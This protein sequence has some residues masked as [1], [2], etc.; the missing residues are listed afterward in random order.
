MCEGLVHLRRSVTQ[1]EPQ[2]FHKK[3][4]STTQ[5]HQENAK[6]SYKASIILIFLDCLF[7]MF[8]IIH[9][10]SLQQNANGQN[11][12]KSEQTASVHKAEL[13]KKNSSCSM[14]L[15]CIEWR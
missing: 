9:F 2:F 5:Q 4:I 12:Q 15:G 6:V 14:Q 3:Q 13:E 7:R 10:R 11:V 1:L 8:R